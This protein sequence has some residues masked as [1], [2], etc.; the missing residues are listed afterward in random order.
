MKIARCRLVGETPYSQGKHVI[1]T[2]DEERNRND[3]EVIRQMEWASRRFPTWIS[4]VGEASYPLT[5]AP[6]DWKP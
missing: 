4:P 3:D 2:P 1:P 6:E 5:L